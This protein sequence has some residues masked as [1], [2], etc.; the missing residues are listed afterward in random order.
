M[1]LRPPASSTG[2]SPPIRKRPVRPAQSRCGP[3]PG[4]GHDGQ[5]DLRSLR[6][7]RRP[8]HRPDRRRLHRAGRHPGERPGRRAGSRPAGRIL[9]WAQTFRDWSLGKPQGFRLVYGDPVPGYEPPGGGAA[10]DAVREVQAEFPGLPPAAVA[11]GLRIRGHLHG[12]VSLKVL[13]HLRAQTTNPAKLYRNE[14]A[15][16]ISSLGLTPPSGTA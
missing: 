14:I 9:A 5:R 6:D 11:L 1:R 7:P 15:R 12:L 13:G 3:S 8:A 2:W 10:P 4:N 16:L